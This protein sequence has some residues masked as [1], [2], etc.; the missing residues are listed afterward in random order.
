MLAAMCLHL[1][2]LSVNNGNLFHVHHALR[3]PCFDERARCVKLQ[4]RSRLYTACSF[5][6]DATVCHGEQFQDYVHLTSP[7]VRTHQASRCEGTWHLGICWGTLVTCESTDGMC[8]DTLG[9]C[10]GTLGKCEGTLGRCEGT[11]G[12]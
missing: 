11:L 7:S 8:E 2:W 4:S 6:R 12:M 3:L 9:M 10:E 1:Q 5:Q